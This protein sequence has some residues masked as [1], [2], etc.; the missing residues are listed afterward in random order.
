[1]VV[2]QHRGKPDFLI[3]NSRKLG[4]TD[5]EI[6]AVELALESIVVRDDI[7]ELSNA[8]RTRFNLH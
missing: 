8:Y 7:D 1:M 4:I 5:T 2:K 6:N 3:L